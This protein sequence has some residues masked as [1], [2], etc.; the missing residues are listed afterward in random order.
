MRFTDSPCEGLMTQVP[1]AR[2]E[3]HGPP[4]RP[5]GHPCRGCPYGRDSPCLGTCCRKLLKGREK[6]AT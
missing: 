3:V 6:N 4:A 2:R 1:T 5:P